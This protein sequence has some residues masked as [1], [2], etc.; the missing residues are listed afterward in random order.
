M[1]FGLK[2]ARATYQLLIN[3]IFKDQI[4]HNMEV[5]VH[6]MLVKSC[7]IGSH[8]DDLEETFV[9]LCKYQMKLILAKYAFKV[10]SGEFL[11]FMVLYRG[12]KP[13]LRKYKT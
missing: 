1:L 6:D 7:A 10:T 5:Y 9:A 12:L 2:N 11:G 4:S 13:T 3:K 8:V